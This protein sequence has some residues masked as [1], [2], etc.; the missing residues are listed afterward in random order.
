[1][2]LSQ[3]MGSLRAAWRAW[4]WFWFRPVTA[5]GLGIMRILMGVMLV[6]TSFDLISD[7]ALLVG[8]DG[9]YSA[10]AAAKGTR[11]GRWT[12]FDHVES[13]DVVYLIHAVNIV[14]NLLF[15]VGFRSRTMGI[16]SVVFHAALYQRN[17]WFMN[18][19]DRLVREFT[20]Y[21]CVV[22]CGAAHSVDAW[23]SRRRAARRG[24]GPSSP[25]IPILAHRLIQVQLCV[26]YTIS[27]LDKLAT[28][29][30]KN[31]NAL[32]YALSSENYQ[33]SPALVDPLLTTQFGQWMLE[34]ASYT[35][36]VWEIGFPLFILW[37]PTRV[38]A[39][40]LGAMIHFGI[41]ATMMVAYFSAASVW[42]YLSFGPYD[43]AERLRDW[44]VKRHQRGLVG[45]S[46]G[47]E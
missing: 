11:M 35:T 32:Y 6:M 36:L 4:S 19:G 44:R 16:L 13:M 9:V 38:L 39:L 21:M 30:W 29:S 47:E 45:A 8:P 26:M 7:L 27:G 20:L 24:E 25:L 22:P 41:F 33:R 14:V 15:L 5:S 12:W 42:A 23:L 1:M 46:P 43:W 37:R 40:V 31:G 3:I 2:P 34:V 17:G 28:G 10:G 18:G